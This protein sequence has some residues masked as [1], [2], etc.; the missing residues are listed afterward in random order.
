MITFTLHDHVYLTRPCLLYTIMFT[1][2]RKDINVCRKGKVVTSARLTTFPAA[3]KLA[4]F[5]LAHSH[6]R[7]TNVGLS[8]ASALVPFS[9]SLRRS[10]SHPT[11]YMLQRQIYNVYPGELILFFTPYHRV[12]LSYVVH[13]FVD[14]DHASMVN[15]N[16]FK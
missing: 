2:H 4:M 14:V 1:L 15:I 6:I 16:H 13:Y 8:T 9:I 10:F 12:I 7:D 3:G 5:F 11:T